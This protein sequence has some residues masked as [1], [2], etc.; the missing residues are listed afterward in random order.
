MYNHVL[1]HQDLSTFLSSRVSVW[2]W[3]KIDKKEDE[4]KVYRRQEVIDNYT[5]STSILLYIMLAL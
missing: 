2:V 3:K 5:T 1:V 4:E